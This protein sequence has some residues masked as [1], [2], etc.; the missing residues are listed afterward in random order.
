M[1]KNPDI[2]F[3]IHVQNEEEHE[4]LLNALEELG[5]DLA[6]RFDETDTI[7][8]MAEKWLGWD[9][10]DACWRISRERGVAYNPSV[11]HW[12]LFTSDIVEKRNGEIVFNEGDYSKEAAEIEKRKLRE[13]F[14]EDDNREF[15]RKQFGLENASDQEVEE[16]LDRKFPQTVSHEETAGTDEEQ[17]HLDY[18]RFQ[19]IHN[20]NRK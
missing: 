10:V 9:G 16:W 17:E 3:V 6:F 8:S 20:G 14:F 7:R 15:I 18:L 1:E 5:Y 4:E 13:D 19:E 2:E 12:R 11:E